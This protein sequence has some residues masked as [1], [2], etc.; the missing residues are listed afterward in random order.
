MPD[1]ETGEIPSEDMEYQVDIHICIADSLL[2]DWYLEGQPWN[3]PRPVPEDFGHM[4]HTPKLP[5]SLMFDSQTLNQIKLSEL[6]SA[7]S[8]MTRP[9]KSKALELGLDS[10]EFRSLYRRVFR[11]VV[12]RAQGFESRG[13]LMFRTERELYVIL[14][15]ARTPGFHGINPHIAIYYDLTTRDNTAKYLR[16]TIGNDD[17]ERFMLR[18]ARP[19]GSYSENIFFTLWN[20]IF[21]DGC[22]HLPDRSLTRYNIDK[23]IISCLEDTRK[24]MPGQT[25]EFNIYRAELQMWKYYFPDT[26]FPGENPYV[27][28]FYE[29][30]G[31]ETENKEAEPEDEDPRPRSVQAH[32]DRDTILRRVRRRNRSI[33]TQFEFDLTAMPGEYIEERPKPLL[34]LPLHRSPPPSDAFPPPRERGTLD[35]GNY[36]DWNEAVLLDDGKTHYVGENRHTYVWLDRTMQASAPDKS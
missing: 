21:R 14:C 11:D 27:E 15:G 5:D 2:W 3:L 34:K 9:L 23:K 36:V 24:D 22:P 12:S 17:E 33:E 28:E 7:Y 26:E 10:K 31:M 30:M 16:N 25:V 18:Y 1:L 35:D 13:W 32:V 19:P 29:M 20:K 6:P 4:V 8:N